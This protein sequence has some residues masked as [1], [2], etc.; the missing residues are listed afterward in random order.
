MIAM[1]DVITFVV[2]ATGYQNNGLT[3][4]NPNLT[5]TY[6]GPSNRD[7]DAPYA[8]PTRGTGTQVG[9]TYSSPN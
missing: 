6:P 7:N 1:S 2:D 8:P 9:S 4:Q 5:G 3:T